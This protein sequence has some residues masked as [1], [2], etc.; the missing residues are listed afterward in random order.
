MPP[1]TRTL[2]FIS[3]S[4]SDGAELAHRIHRSL[5]EEGFEVWLDTQRIPVSAVWT[6]ELEEA[7]DQSNVV[8]AVLTQGSYRSDICRAEHLRALRKQKPLFPVLAQS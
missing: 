5:L 4:R 7:L 1:P 6:T 2:V 8:L 3:Y